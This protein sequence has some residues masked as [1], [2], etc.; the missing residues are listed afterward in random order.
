MLSSLAIL[1]SLRFLFKEKEKYY[2]EVFIDP[3]L[4]FSL[5]KWC[6]IH[7]H[8]S[9]FKVGTQQY[10]FSFF[11]LLLFYVV[12]V[13]LFCLLTSQCKSKHYCVMINVNS[14]FPCLFSCRLWWW[15]FPWTKPLGMCIFL[16]KL[17]YLVIEYFM[18]GK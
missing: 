3:G 12:V 16:L 4:I 15:D 9:P 8:N 7:V 1:S 11:I 17:L 14:W 2:F 18:V 13:S 10:Y 6:Q 5:S